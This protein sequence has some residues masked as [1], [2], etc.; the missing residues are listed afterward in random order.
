MK[1]FARD[2][3]SVALQLGEAGAARCGSE[4]NEQKDISLIFDSVRIMFIVRAGRIFRSRLGL[5]IA[6]V[7]TVWC[8]INVALYLRFAGLAAQTG[9]TIPARLTLVAVLVWIPLTEASLLSFAMSGLKS[10][11]RVGRPPVKVLAAISIL[12]MIAATAIVLLTVITGWVFRIQRMSFPKPSVVRALFAQLG[13]VI[14]WM[15]FREVLLLT[16]AVGVG[17]LLA[18]AL[19]RS[20]PVPSAAEFKK[21][22]VLTA[23]NCLILGFLIRAVPPQFKP[24][25]RNRIEALVK[26]DFLPTSTLIWAQ[27]LLPDRRDLRDEEILAPRRGISTPEHFRKRPN[28]ILISVESLRGGEESRISGQ[29]YVMPTLHRL[30]NEG[31]HF[32]RAYA[33]SNES[34]YSLSAIFTSQHMLK[35]LA[36]DDFRKPAVPYV[37]MYDLLP[38]TY[39]EGVLLT[40]TQEEW[41][42]MGAVSQSPKLDRF[43]DASHGHQL[44]CS[45]GFRCRH[46]ASE[47]PPDEGEVPTG[48]LWT[49]N[50]L[51]RA[52]EEWVDHLG[53]PAGGS[54][55]TR[56]FFAVLKFEE[57][58]FPYQQGFNVPIRFSPAALSPSESR[59]L[60]FFSYP[61]ELAPRLQRRYWKSL[62]YDDGLIQQVLEHLRSRVALDDTVVMVFGDHGELF[63]ENG[64]TTHADRLWEQTLHTPSSCGAPRSGPRP[65]IG[66]AN[67]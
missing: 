53:P 58:H 21:L 61:R 1:S 39:T 66:T 20:A 27:L 11:W 19:F 24:H 42:N 57:S 64:A 37:R 60:S 44:A 10:L 18:A 62:S 50:A 55:S 13:S 32:T 4:S 5:Y 40:R 41:Q 33:P 14:P 34:A 56:P 46:Q 31:V 2:T 12:T 6:G 9:L 16:L 43:F 38:E 3:P 8:L 35:T 25:E 52:F 23:V 51:S 49:T 47:T 45:I 48:A 36:R 29:D 67:R 30:A 26:A 54:L 22:S 63:Y 65:S 15:T 17:G 7:A 59:S 28:I